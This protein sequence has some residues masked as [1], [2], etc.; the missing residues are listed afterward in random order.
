MNNPDDDPSNCANRR[1]FLTGASLLFAGLSM[2]HAAEATSL[3]S[4]NTF[5]LGNIIPLLIPLDG[6][7]NAI[8]VEDGDSVK[9]GASIADTESTELNR[10]LIQVNTAITLAENNASFML[11][12]YMSCV[13]NLLEI[14][15]ETNSQFEATTEKIR[16][17]YKTAIKIGLRDQY[18]IYPR[19][20]SCFRAEGES[21]RSKRILAAYTPEYEQL[22]FRLNALKDALQNELKV[23][24]DM[25]G[26]MQLSAPVSGVVRL[27]T[28][29]GSFV[30]KGGIVAYIEIHK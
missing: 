29:V 3:M 18:E 19:D 16:N 14:T 26:R 23:V 25:Q 13:R 20:L 28:G 8:H 11:G 30:P 21:K 5:D 10:A 27:L 7:V 12:E 17:M 6:H 22:K 1:S 9:K 4:N 2:S 15:A 24:Q